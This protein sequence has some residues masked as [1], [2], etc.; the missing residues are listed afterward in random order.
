MAAFRVYALV[1]A[2]GRSRRFGADKLLAELRGRPVLAHVLATVRDAIRKTTLHGGLAVIPAGVPE[3]EALLA[4]ADF[5]YVRNP[6]PAAGVARSLA[7]G[8]ETL[9]AR[10]P[11]ADAALVFQGDQPLLPGD[12]IARLVAAGR[13]STPVVRPR[14]AGAPGVPGHPVLLHRS[15][16]PRAGELRGDAG[17]APLLRKYPELVT[18]IDVPGINP[19]ISTPSDLARLESMAR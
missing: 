6:D 11:D 9:A 15:F 7:L 3:R 17:F 12:V 14:F 10:H 5:E 4:S 1:L 18:A 19:D 8:L 13:E 2:A 16:W